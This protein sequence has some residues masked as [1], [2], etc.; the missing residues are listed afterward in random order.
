MNY[1]IEVSR[2]P[3]IAQAMDSHEFPVAD[4]LA[5]NL[6]QSRIPVNVRWSP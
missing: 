6:Q 3:D 5:A 1:S 2:Q 4:S